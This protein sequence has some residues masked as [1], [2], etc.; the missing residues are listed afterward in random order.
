MNSLSIIAALDLG[1]R[2]VGVAVSDPSNLLARPFETI[3]RSALNDF[4]KNF[5]EQELVHT[6]V[7]G[8]PKT[9]RGTE[10]EQTKKVVAEFEQLKKD[11]PVITW[12]L[13]DE[14]LSSKQASHIKKEKTKEDKIASHA[15]AAA[16]I[17]QGYL[18]SLRWL[19]KE[20]QSFD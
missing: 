12:K 13:F 19:K 17:L 8:Y 6:M 11:F 2:W 16:L 18:E 10:S 20:D 3:E 4:L 9:L 5:I 1:D 14:R 15:R 7:V